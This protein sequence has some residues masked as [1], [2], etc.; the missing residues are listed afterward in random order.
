MNSITQRPWFTSLSDDQQE[1]IELSIIL[2]QRELNT[3]SSLSDYSFILFPIAKAYEG[4]LKL[5]LL[6]MGLITQQVYEGK[7]FRIGRA[8]NP[9]IHDNQRDEYWLFDDLQ[10]RCG[11]TVARSLWQ[12]WLECRN[13]V[14]HYYPSGNKKLTLDSVSNHLDII[15]QT[16]DIAFTCKL[17]KADQFGVSISS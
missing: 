6:E 13:R 7:R 4:F 14:F 16:M 5:Y 12:T 8:I 1:M 2:Y 9:D 11:E 15:E 10:L 17:E 3:N